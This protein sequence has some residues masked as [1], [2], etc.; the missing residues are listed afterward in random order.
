MCK[1]T[2]CSQSE[3]LCKIQDALI[4]PLD[5]LFP[6]TCILALVHTVLLHH[7]Y[8]KW[9]PNSGVLIPPCTLLDVF[10]S[11]TDFSV[12]CVHEKNM[13]ALN[14]IQFLI[15]IRDGQ[16]DGWIIY[17]CCCCYPQVIVSW[18]ISTDLALCLYPYNALIFHAPYSV[19]IKCCSMYC[20]SDMR[21]S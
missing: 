8:K 20:T 10:W 18:Q 14:N 19:C 17:Q 6:H 9:H 12:V 11:V 4:H 16:Y 1:V 3:H 7:R 21:V 13:H 5:I 15:S 2:K